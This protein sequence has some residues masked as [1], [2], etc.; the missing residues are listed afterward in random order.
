MKYDVQGILWTGAYYVLS[1]V[2][3]SQYII[4]INRKHCQIS[5]KP[6]DHMQ[7]HTC[8]HTF[9]LRRCVCMSSD[10]MGKWADIASDQLD[11]EMKEK[12]LV[13]F[14]IICVLIIIDII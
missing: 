5:Y 8:C 9:R 12:K 7:T 3:F 10:Q 13:L 11:K 6:L 1:R 2:M 4:D 14:L